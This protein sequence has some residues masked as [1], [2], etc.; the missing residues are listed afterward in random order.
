MRWLSVAAVLRNVYLCAGA[1]LNFLKAAKAHRKKNK[2]W[3]LWIEAARIMSYHCLFQLLDLF[4]C[5]E[6]EI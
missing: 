5:E 6:T 1:K 2:I 4:F 3:D